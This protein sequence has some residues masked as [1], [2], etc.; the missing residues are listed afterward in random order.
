M[1]ERES[2]KLLEDSHEYWREGRRL[3]SVTQVLDACG[4]YRY[5]GN[6]NDDALDRGTVVHQCCELLDLGRLDESTVEPELAGY[7]DAYREAKR[8]LGLEFLAIEAPLSGTGYAGT[9]D[10]IGARRDSNRIVI[11]DIKTTEGEPL[12]HWRLQTAAYADMF[13]QAR[14]IERLA[15]ALDS[16]GRFRATATSTR[17]NCDDIRAW[18]SCLS[19]Y[20][21][22][23]RNL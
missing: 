2:V 11:M 18:T 3:P 7:L 17:Q 9:P 19:L 8:E 10:R 23:E 5:F 22:R 13:Q 1:L 15:I 4:F 6:G 14:D 21:W 20:S 16:S 12:A